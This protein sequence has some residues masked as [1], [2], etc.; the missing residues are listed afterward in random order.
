MLILCF[1]LLL[2][3]I[4][5]PEASIRGA[6]EGLALCSR[7]VIP[8][9]FPFL[10]LI[11][12][13]LPYL[14]SYGG[15][16]LSAYVLSFL[17]GYP[18]GVS[19]VLT[20]YQTG[21]LRKHQAERLLGLCN[22]SGPGFFLTVIGVGLFRDIRAGYILFAVHVMASLTI[23]A[24]EK[25][26]DTGLCQIRK[27]DKGKISFPQAFQDALSKACSNTLLICGTVV[28]F[29][30]LLSFLKMLLPPK[31]YPLAG[32]LELC[33]GISVLQDN[34]L[35]F[36]LCAV[37]MGWGG[38]CVHLQAMSLWEKAGIR[39]IHYWCNKLLHGLLSGLYAYALIKRQLCVFP[40]IIIFICIYR[41]FCKNGLEKKHLMM[42]N[43]IQ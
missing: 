43:K 1:S 3:I 24:T 38:L 27:E 30:V 6:C 23:M 40:I 4:L 34:E 12:L 5:F 21:K 14:P 15:R 35:S 13:L 41:S 36:V 22:N 2:G 31:W 9:L 16:A 37:Y 26:M 42:Y 11:P 8:A 19:G 7:S 20:L 32:L 28:A 18:S 39:P 33:N 10:L 29:S 17:G 25:P